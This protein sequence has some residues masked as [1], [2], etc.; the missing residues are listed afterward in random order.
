MCAPLDSAKWFSVWTLKLQCCDVGD[1]FTSVMEGVTKK[2]RVLLAVAAYISTARRHLSCLLRLCD[3]HGRGGTDAQAMATSIEGWGG[4]ERVTAPPEAR[5][6]RIPRCS[7]LRCQARQLASILPTY[8]IGS[9]RVRCWFSTTQ[10][11][12]QYFT[13]T[14][15]Y[16][17]IYFCELY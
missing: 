5:V 2:S 9:S 11:V 16:K 1:F 7:W 8:P 12:M 17:D 13:K 10:I 14:P 3:V 4:G 15:L 6:I